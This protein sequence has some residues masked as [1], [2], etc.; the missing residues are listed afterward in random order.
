MHLN[1]KT[2][3]EPWNI[4]TKILWIIQLKAHLCPPDIQEQIHPH[5]ISNPSM[6]PYIGM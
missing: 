3:V 2:W 6:C 4:P 5:S 1:D